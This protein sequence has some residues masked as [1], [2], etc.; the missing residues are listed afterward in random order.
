[1]SDH[2][3]DVDQIDELTGLSTFNSFRVLAQ[4]IL[5]DPTIRND[6]A[7]VY[8]N[9]E[10]FRS[11]NEKYGFS[12]GNDCLRIIGQTIQA[13][14]P[15]EVCSRVATD[16][17][18][19]VADKNEIEEKIK[20]ICEELRPF[21]METHMQLHAGIYFP[22]K[23]DFEC[24]FCLD[25][26]KIA[27]DSLKH[28][29]DSMF[30]YYD[31]KLDDD[32]QRTRYIIEH[33]DDAIEKGYI[34]AWFQPL[35]RSFTGEI[36]GYEALARW[37]DP[38]LGFISPADFVP[39]LEKYHMIRRL[40]LAV[41]RYVCNVQ[42]KVM[43]DGGQIM[44]VSINLSQQDFVGGDIVSEIDE[45][46]LDSGIPSEYINIEITE[47]IFSLDS[48]RVKNIIDAFRLQGYEVWM[49]DFGSGY[50]SLNSMQMFTFD[51]LKLDMSFLEGFNV[52]RNSKII[53][54]SVIGMTK[55]LGIR[56]IAEGVETVE[57]AEYLKKVGCDQ[58]QGFLYSKP[59]PFEE[60]YNLDI[61]KENTG[62]RKYHEKIGTVN[63]LS[64]NPLGSEED[65]AK[66]IMFPIALV[67][68]YKGEISLLTFN[69]T[70]TDY[71][72][73]LGFSS[74]M[75]AERFINS[76]NESAVNFRNILVTV[77]ENDKCEVCHYTR[78]GHRC[79]LQINYIANYRSRN[80]FLFL[81]LVSENE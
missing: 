33:F 71:V 63:L 41:T 8:F 67:E 62:L 65:E 66:K 52:S 27:C 23:N 6:I 11:Y 10:N 4:D 15:Q 28:Q 9:V 26:A 59:G 18:C 68:E 54:E 72:S 25:K 16:H 1:M 38:E 35:V 55:Q 48:E 32:Y 42:N 43:K 31:E 20:Q 5:D 58:I 12:A 73:M 77:I 34:M 53:I 37:L 61:P 49:D 2:F 80:A 44:P 70:F 40:D 39:V 3:N 19:V 14:F 36:S 81:G 76:D 24:T 64:Q 17:F 30:G 46:V 29:Y 47:S 21:R 45:I 69:E 13:I 60:V 7:F 22:D 79:T 50:S 51:C 56:T 74:P 75:E 57:E 78:N